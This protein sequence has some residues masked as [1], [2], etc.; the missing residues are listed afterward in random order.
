MCLY[1]DA[2]WSVVLCLH[3]HNSQ[4]APRRGSNECVKTYTSE[5]L[6][7]WNT[8]S[9]TADERWAEMFRHFKQSHVPFKNISALCQFAMCLPGT[10]APVERIFSIMNN[11]W[12]DERNR[13]SL[14]TLKALLITRV[15]IHVSCSEF[16]ESITPNHSFLKKVHS[17]LKY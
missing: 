7:Q 12:T 17:S 4:A 2:H 10:N 16:Y 3:A 11:T 1:L 14:D 8:T 5:K 9:T 15:N 6:E 13:M